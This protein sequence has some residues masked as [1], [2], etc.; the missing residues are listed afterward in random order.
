MFQDQ[1][2]SDS[3]AVVG[4]GFREVLGPRS[5]GPSLRWAALVGFEQKRNMLCLCSENHYDCSFVNRLKGEASVDEV[6]AAVDDGLSLHS[7]E[8]E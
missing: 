4:D 2:L 6:E 3:K 8:R 5:Q 1:C 7:E